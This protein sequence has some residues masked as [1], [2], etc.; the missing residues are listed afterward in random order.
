M[1]QV[2]SL[3]TNGT[4]DTM[5]VADGLSS[6]GLPARVVWGAAVQFQRLSYGE[7][8]A[9]DLGAM[10][11][12]IPGGKHFTPEDHPEEVAGAVNELLSRQRPAT[13]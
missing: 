12:S 2:T 4:N 10:V 1:R 11:P 9:T 7:R 3:D 6:L 5:A 13:W 8:L